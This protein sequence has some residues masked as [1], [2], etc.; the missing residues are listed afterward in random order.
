M[1]KDISSWPEDGETDIKPDLAIYPTDAASKAIYERD[2]DKTKIQDEAR[3]PHAARA[4]WALMISVGEVK[5][6]D[7]AAGFH[8]ETDELLNESGPGQLARAQHAKYANEILYR[9]HRL[10]LFTFYISGCWARAFYWDR[11]GCALTNAVNLVENPLPFQ[12][13][14]YR[15]AHG[16]DEDRGFDPTVKLAEESE[17]EAWR[18]YRTNNRY[19]QQYRNEA[20]RDTRKY[21][22]CKVC[23][24]FY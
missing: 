6:C 17:M 16:S 4:A 24:P 10:H 11:N 22:V 8:F 18:S 13:F 19:L 15:L 14:L 2:I 7:A 23:S 9:Q 20:L 1:V 12:T 5:N 3:V 21:P